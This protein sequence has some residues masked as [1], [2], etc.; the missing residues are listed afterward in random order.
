MKKQS[1][2]EYKKELLDLHDKY[3]ALRNCGNAD[4]LTNE[5]GSF[6]STLSLK[7]DE[8]SI[9]YLE[10]ACQW[11]FYHKDFSYIEKIEKILALEGII[12]NLLGG[13]NYVTYWSHKLTL[14][15]KI[16]I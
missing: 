10:E 3:I 8:I 1:I 5:D 6:K 7:E 15:Y 13:I 12:Q 2:K 16:D 4:Q 11:A 14:S 9:G